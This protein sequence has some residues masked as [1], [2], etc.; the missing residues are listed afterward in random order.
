VST[1]P[2]LRAPSSKWL[3]NQPDKKHCNAESNEEDGYTTNQ[4]IIVESRD[5]FEARTRPQ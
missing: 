2:K 3:T 5:Q 1:P 4:H